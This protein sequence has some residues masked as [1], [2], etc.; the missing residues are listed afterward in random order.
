L[1]VHKRVQLKIM[2]SMI[3]LAPLCDFTCYTTN[4]RILTQKCK[5]QH[6][7]Q[8]ARIHG[9]HEF[10]AFVIIYIYIS[11]LVTWCSRHRCTGGGVVGGINTLLYEIFQTS[12]QL[13]PTSHSFVL[14]SEQQFLLT[15]C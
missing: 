15:V 4:L 13:H 14:Y 1:N 8:N 12:Q 7:A 5:P 9:C 2:I 11:R 3:V 6:D 10:S